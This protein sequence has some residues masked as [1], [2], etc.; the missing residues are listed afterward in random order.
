VPLDNTVDAKVAEAIE[1]AAVRDSYS[2]WPPIITQ[3]R[4]ESPLS[5]IDE[6]LFKGNTTD[7]PQP[8]YFN[9]PRPTSAPIPP[10]YVCAGDGVCRPASAHI[11]WEHLH[12]AKTGGTSLSFALT[13]MLCGPTMGAMPEGLEP[14]ELRGTRACVNTM[15]DT[16]LSWPV[17]AEIEGMKR[18]EHAG[19]DAIALRGANMQKALT[20]WHISPEPKIVFVT[21]LRDGKS[22]AMSHWAHCTLQPPVVVNDGS[23]RC[24]LGMIPMPETP[25]WDDESLLLFLERDS[26]AMRRSGRPKQGLRVNNALVGA[27]SSLPHPDVMLNPA[28]LEL[29]KQALLSSRYELSDGRQL[30]G[31]SWVVG[32]TECLD[33]MYVHLARRMGVPD[34]L[35]E[36]TAGVRYEKRFSEHD[37]DVTGRR[38]QLLLDSDPA[39]RLLRRLTDSAGLTQG[40]KMAALK[41]GLDNSLWLWAHMMAG[42]QRGEVLRRF[43]GE[44]SFV[45]C[46]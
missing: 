46:S 40:S 35:A 29:A 17:V 30:Q 9:S 1:S 41:N 18:E 22:R 27:L 3:R 24:T 39:E 16:E 5:R 45:G 14:W 25:R 43:D 23:R 2:L 38:R 8:A 19:L 33:D 15:L 7:A 31:F 12:V 36:E 4:E 42:K 32:F 34:H 13:N 6:E 28:H 11:L 21:A 10:E 44:A 20:P 37:A 26:Q